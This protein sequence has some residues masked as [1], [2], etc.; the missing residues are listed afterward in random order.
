MLRT[1]AT[2]I[3]VPYMPQ[4][5]MLKQKLGKS[6][7]LPENRQI[8]NPSKYKSIRG[9]KGGKRAKTIGK[10]GSCRKGNGTNKEEFMDFRMRKRAYDRLKL[11][12]IEEAQEEVRQGILNDMFRVTQMLQPTDFQDEV[13]EDIK[14]GNQTTEPR[15][16]TFAGEEG[17]GDDKTRIKF[18]NFQEFCFK[19]T[20][21]FYP[22]PV[23]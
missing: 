15:V 1:G 5:E 17:E 13:K 10:Y 2:S 20:G 6:P 11:K 12:L 4:S 21:S 23:F 3:Q 22:N 19:T 8:K 14:G 7:M 16:P 18:K 9:P